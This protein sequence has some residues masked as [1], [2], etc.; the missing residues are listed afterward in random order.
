VK[1]SLRVRLSEVEACSLKCTFDSAQGDTFRVFTQSES[2]SAL[3]LALIEF[4]QAQRR[5]ENAE[6]FFVISLRLFVLICTFLL[7]CGLSAGGIF[8]SESVVALLAPFIEHRPENA[9]W[10]S[11]TA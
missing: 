9:S 3:L 1:T 6:F 7:G 4:T 11:G 2:W 8:S 10:T 5:K